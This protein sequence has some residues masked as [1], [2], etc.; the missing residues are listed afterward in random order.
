MLLTGSLNQFAPVPL[1]RM[2]QHGFA[3]CHRFGLA[4]DDKIHC[5]VARFA[6]NV[7]AEAFADDALDPVPVNGAAAVFP[8]N[9][10]AEPV[11][12]RCVFPGK[13]LQVSIL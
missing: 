1:Q 10:H 2:M 13:D 9:R 12:G 7:L 3:R 4:H 5:H 8:C 6:G 11:S